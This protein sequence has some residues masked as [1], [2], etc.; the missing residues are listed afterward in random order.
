MEQKII[1]L[2]RF[3]ELTGEKYSLFEYHKKQKKET[4]TIEV[5]K[6]EQKEIEK[7]EVA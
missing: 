4:K 7:Q 5:K 1:F 2:Q 3:L 6:Q